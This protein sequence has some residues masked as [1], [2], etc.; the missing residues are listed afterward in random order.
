MR[1]PGH[2]RLASLAVTGLCGCIAAPAQTN[3]LPSGFI[4]RA[5][6]AAILPAGTRLERAA[7]AG[8][9]LFPGD[10]VNAA[11]GTVVLDYCPAGSSQKLE[12]TTG[13]RLSIPREAPFATNLPGT[14]S[15][16]VDPCDLP[17][18]EREPEVATVR[19]AKE[20]APQAVPPATLISHIQAL[21]PA[22]QATLLTLA[23]GDLTNPRMRL[24]LAVA[25]EREGLWEE[26]IDQYARLAAMW[27]D[28]PRLSKYMERLRARPAARSI[29]QP[30][31]AETVAAPSGAQPTKGRIHALVIGISKYEQREIRDLSYAD[32]DATDFA[33]YLRTPRGGV[34]DKDHLEVLLNA[35]AT[36]AE[37]RNRMNALKSG[38]GKD[39]TVIVFAA[40]HGDMWQ[41]A[42]RLITHR[43]DPQYIGISAYPM[44]QFQQL[45]DGQLAPW[46]RALIFLDICH[47]GHLAQF[48][49]ASQSL[50]P[51]YLMM[52]AANP[53]T[54][55]KGK[56]QVANAYE[57]VVFGGGHGAFT[58][59]LLRGLNTREAKLSDGELISAP[60][61]KLY[62][63]SK[64]AQATSLQQNPATV[65]NMGK[66]TGVAD[67]RLAGLPG[68]YTDLTQELRLAS[69]RLRSAARSRGPQAPAQP[70]LAPLESPA[71][72]ELQARISLENEGD[73]ILLRYLRGE[74]EPLTRSDFA[75]GESLFRQALA[76]QPA[77]PYLMA[78][79]EFCEGR[80]L[81][82]DK[83]YPDSMA[84]LERSIRLDPGAAY[85][86]NAL[87]IDYLEQARYDLATRAFQDA[88]ARA[89]FWAYPVHNLALAQLQSGD[90]EGAIG[91]YRKAMLL[92]PQYS[93]LPY[94]L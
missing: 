73:E 19:S 66:D 13:A 90:Y 65:F 15:S 50:V 18:F 67:L 25:L 70:P 91:S 87:G 16:P 6:R 49:V 24:A 20:L 84:H 28:Q 14:Q 62:V 41:G 33:T 52:M 31:A 38:A 37:I 94:N 76:L 4:L 7:V 78:R 22:A 89:P 64:V 47:S 58:Y 56:L 42:P 39:D 3:D 17:P 80:K 9:I 27:P 12:I 32:R 92:A 11:G 86:Y 77:S 59:F 75:R 55:S 68:P 5:E 71:E 21:P 8:D 88:I 29:R 54:E 60:E 82:F 34:G 46:G 44:K 51:N 79:A 10:V 48:Q 81:V 30:D 23:L 63:E 69:T 36:T 83:S 45:L 74:E 2:A 40:G 85:A 1:V 53:M 43:A 93:Y 57:D 61:L 26:A 35:E 72:P